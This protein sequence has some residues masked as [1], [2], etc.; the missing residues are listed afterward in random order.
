MKK[1]LKRIAALLLAAVMVFSL[2]AC[3]GQKTEK[4]NLLT[5]LQELSL[6]DRELGLEGKYGTLDDI[7]D[8]TVD[9][10]LIGTWKT[11]D[12]D[13]TYTFGETGELK[14]SSVSYNTEDS[15]RFTCLTAD[16]HK[17]L[18]EEYDQVDYS[19]DEPVTEK[20][21]SYSAY[22][23]KNGALYIVGVETGDEH[24]T[25]YSSSLTVMYKADSKGSIEAAVKAN[26]L[27]PASFAGEWTVD[28]DG[29]EEKTKVVMDEKSLTIGSDVYEI[30]F[31]ADGNM[32]VT[33]DGASTTY[34][35]NVVGVRQ[36][37]SDDRA[38]VVDDHYM[39]GFYY[40]GADEND[41]PNLEGVMEDW[42]AT[43][44]VDEF[45]FSGAFV[46]AR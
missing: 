30:S 7:T 39:F 45:R 43:Y 44:G 24:M 1:N 13:V 27:D 33:K 36:Y 31:D 35:F 32:T 41:R 15:T 40:L 17:I 4:V 6:R 21:V 16:G 29:A 22:E 38:Q 28:D 11:A 14:M 20:V 18:C 37:E 3:G 12:G 26:P 2:A 34:D 19:S 23:V 5:K 9:K 10:D 46:R 8:G 42:H 25:F